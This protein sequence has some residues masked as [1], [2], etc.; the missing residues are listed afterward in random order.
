MA[1]DDDKVIAPSNADS[2]APAAAGPAK[3]KRKVHSPER[4]K[5]SRLSP[6][7]KRELDERL[8]SGNFGGFRALSRWL[9]ER[10]GVH[11]SA[12]SLNYYYRF[13]FEDTLEAVGKAARQ[14]DRFER[15][16]ETE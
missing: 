3:P 1:S 9:E 8:A 16:L 11:V 2:A 13:R 14:A 6:E 5:L 15:V 7:V 4:D 10:S 12:A